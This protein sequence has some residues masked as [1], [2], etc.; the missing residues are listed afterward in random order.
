M[1]AEALFEAL[2]SCHAS[3]KILQEGAPRPEQQAASQCL[4]RHAL[5]ST[6]TL[7]DAE[8]RVSKTLEANKQMD[9]DVF[10]PKD[11]QRVPRRY[12]NVALSIGPRSNVPHTFLTNPKSKAS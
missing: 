4:Q 5:Q 2:Q 9:S 8:L 3:G 12:K 11:S 7:H 10:D 6:F 1:M